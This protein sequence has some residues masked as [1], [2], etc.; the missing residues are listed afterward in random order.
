MLERKDMWKKKRHRKRA[1]IRRRRGKRRRRRRKRGRGRRRRRRSGTGQIYA[2]LPKACLAVALQ[3]K[4]RSI[5][6]CSALVLGSHLCYCLFPTDTEAFE[7][8]TWLLKR[9]VKPAKCSKPQR[10]SGVG[11]PS[12]IISRSGY[13]YPAQPHFWPAWLEK[14][15]KYRKNMKQQNTKI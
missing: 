4:L 11:N 2:R 3:H 15:Q 5:I 10:I 6:G 7:Q 1:N 12:L 9:I 14:I 13:S 8:Q